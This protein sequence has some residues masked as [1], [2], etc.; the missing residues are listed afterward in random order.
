MHSLTIDSD[1]K[2]QVVDI[3][4]RVAELVPDGTGV[5]QLFIQHTTAALSLMDLDPGTDED[6]LDFLASLIPQ[7][8]WRHPHN[9]SH[10]PDHL[11][12]SLVG[13]HLAVPYS[14]GR[15][16]LGTWQRVVLVEFDGPRQRN[17]VV[18]N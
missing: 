11:L 4:D 7:I 16:R 13:S 3:T 1:H 14:E 17:V 9:P 12:A 5:L 18:V 8:D 15:L 10:A 6:F 2:R